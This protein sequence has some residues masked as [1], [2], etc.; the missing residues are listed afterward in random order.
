MRDR[1]ETRTSGKRADCYVVRG[2]GQI[3]PTFDDRSGR[4]VQ[5]SSVYRTGQPLD[6]RKHSRE[7]RQVPEFGCDRRIPRIRTAEKYRIAQV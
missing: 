7:R 1:I 4:A 5:N 3:L 2:S 6:G